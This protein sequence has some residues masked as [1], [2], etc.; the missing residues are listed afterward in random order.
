MLVLSCENSFNM[1]KSL[2]EEQSQSAMKKTV[3]INRN[4]T[5]G[6]DLKPYIDVTMKNVDACDINIY[7]FE[8]LLAE[9]Y[10]F[11]GNKIKFY[12]EEKKVRFNLLS[13]EIRGKKYTNVSVC[14]NYTIKAASSNL[15]VINLSTI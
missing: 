9:E 1:T 7:D 4:V 8:A 6:F 3:K 11:N 14:Y 13:A 2:S 10:F 15:N 12:Q 5:G